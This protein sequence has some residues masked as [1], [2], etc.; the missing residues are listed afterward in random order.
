MRIQLLI[1]FQFGLSLIPILCTST[2][3]GKI[4]VDINVD[5]KFEP[6]FTYICNVRIEHI[7]YVLFFY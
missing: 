6:L 4:F 5:S 3:Q 2:Y 7:H 1:H